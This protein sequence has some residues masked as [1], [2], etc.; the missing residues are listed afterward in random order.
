MDHMTVDVYQVVIATLH[1]IFTVTWIGGMMIYVYIILSSARKTIPVSKQRKK[2]MMDV[3]EKLSLLVII[4]MVN[5]LG[6]GLILMPDSVPRPIMFVFIT[7]YATIFTYKLYL[8]I[9]ALVI[10]LFKLVYVD[11]YIKKPKIKR[12]WIIITVNV[13]IIVGL[14]LIYLSV[15]LRYLRGN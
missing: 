12:R 11:L 15:Y 14:V 8:S 3:R 5:L 6:T 7:P 4:S 1:D 2:F 10:I 9:L 13:N